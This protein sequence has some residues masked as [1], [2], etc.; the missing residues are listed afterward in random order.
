MRTGGRQTDS[1]SDWN[2]ADGV[3]AHPDPLP[4]GEGTAVGRCWFCG[5]LSGKSS[6]GFSS[7]A[8]S[9]S[10]SPWGEGRGEG[11][12]YVKLTCRLFV[13]CPRHGGL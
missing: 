7:E 11:E 2:H 8:K 4:R 6:R 10:P 13:P 5:A 12:L 1:T 9:D 3:L